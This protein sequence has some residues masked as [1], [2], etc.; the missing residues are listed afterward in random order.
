MWVGLVSSVER[1]GAKAKVSQKRRNL[2]LDCR[3]SPHLSRVFKKYF[4]YVFTY[5]RERENESIWKE[6][7][8][9][10]H[11]ERRALR[12][13]PSHDPEIMT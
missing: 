11:P 10:F 9:I 4:I 13:A 8:S 1:L 5:L 12:E 6:G 2:L 7:T 3:I